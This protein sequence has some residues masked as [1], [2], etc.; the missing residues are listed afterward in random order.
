MLLFYCTCSER[1]P[2]ILE[3]GIR[4][5]LLWRKLVRAKG[6]GGP[7]VL[8]VDIIGLIDDGESDCLRITY[9]PPSAFKNLS[10]YLEPREVCA[11]GGVVVRNGKTSPEVLLI[12]RHGLWDLPKGKCMSGESSHDCAEREVREETGIGALVVKN[13]V[14]K[15]LHGYE[16]RGQYHVKRTCWYLMVGDASN[17]VPQQDEGITEVRWVSWEAAIPMLGYETLQRLLRRVAPVP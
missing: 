11:A 1:L 3:H 2:Q 13:A 10:P 9:V 15:T 12:R 8:V 14:G 7:I 6:M 4:D 5:A 16:R 17:F